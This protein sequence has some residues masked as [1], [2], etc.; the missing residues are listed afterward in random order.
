VRP[1]FGDHRSAVGVADEDCRAVLLVEHVE[2]FVGASQMD[3]S[4]AGGKSAP[5]VFAV[6]EEHSRVLERPT[7]DVRE[8]GDSL[9]V[10]PLHIIGRRQEPADQTD[11][12]AMLKYSTEQHQTQPV[13]HS[14]FG[15]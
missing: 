7:A 2:A 6:D 9:E 11:H 12:Q 13:G 1:G 5:E 4:V 10:W 15:P 3:A 14:R 8:T